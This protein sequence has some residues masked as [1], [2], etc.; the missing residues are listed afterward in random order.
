MT[1]CLPELANI[2]RE[3][4][5]YSGL[6]QQQDRVG[7]GRLT[8][9]AAQSSDPWRN[10]IPGWNPD[11]LVSNAAFRDGLPMRLGVRVF[12]D[13]L[14]CSLCQ[15]HLDVYGHHCMCCMGQGYKQVMHTSFRNVVYHLA[16]RAGAAPCLEPTN[17]LPEMP[18]TRRDL[19]M[20]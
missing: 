14:V 20:C 12:D 8:A 17:L 15:S 6:L 19:Q 5:Q 16:A 9:L 1:A 4:Q 18:Q 7:Q 13:S 11:I 2:F 3:P 10:A